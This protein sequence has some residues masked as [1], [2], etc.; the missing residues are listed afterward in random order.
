VKKRTIVA[1]GVGA[2]AVTI[3]ATLVAILVPHHSTKSK[4]TATHSSATRPT[5]G[6]TGTKPTASP[7]PA[8][9][10][11]VTTVSWHKQCPQGYKFCASFPGE[12]FESNVHDSATSRTGRRIS[13]DSHVYGDGHGHF[14]PGMTDTRCRGYDDGYFVSI[15]DSKFSDQWTA[16]TAING[17]LKNPVRTTVQN[18]LAAKFDHGIYGG[19]GITVYYD[20]KVYYAEAFTHNLSKA[21]FIDQ[22]LTSIQFT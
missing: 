11:L 14:C 19:P 5:T 12:D 15:I 21:P 8:S 7:S 22:F 1:T 17:G 16:L 4:P 3:I 2:V 10:P 20:G 6:Q 13:F 9:S 18:N